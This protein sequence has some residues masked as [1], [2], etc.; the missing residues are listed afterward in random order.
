MR[1]G[2]EDETGEMHCDLSNLK[3][4]V[5]ED[6]YLVADELTRLLKKC[7]AEVM[8]PVQSGDRA[9][10]A[11]DRSTPDIALLDIN[12]GGESVYPVAEL[13]KRRGVPIIFV[14]G[15]AANLIRG[16][17]ADAPCIDKPFD[18][19]RLLAE[20]ERVRDRT[21]QDDQATRH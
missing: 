10:E 17:F 14:T 21:K 18:T 15:Y 1:D 8:G 7:K 9:R 2:R 4:L 5:V 20:I 16:D 3:I 12:L 19:A 11:L 6:Q 13:L